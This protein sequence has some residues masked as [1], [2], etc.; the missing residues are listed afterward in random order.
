MGWHSCTRNPMTLSTS[1]AAAAMTT[2]STAGP[3][4]YFRP[5][6]PEVFSNP[7]EDRGYSNILLTTR[8]R[9]LT[10]FT[11]LTLVTLARLVL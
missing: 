5:M 3:V 6:P 4:P 2:I 11:R 7:A 1:A 10:R 8:T 9:I